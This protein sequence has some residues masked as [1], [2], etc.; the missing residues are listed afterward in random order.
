MI[1]IL[2]Y[3]PGWPRAF[4][5]EAS[6]LHAALPLLCAL[7]HIGSTAVPGLAAKPVIDMMGAVDSLDDLPHFFPVLGQ[8]GYS[9]VE[10]GMRDRSFL[11]RPGFNL[12][13]VTFASWPRR[14]ERLLRDA[15]IADPHAAARYGA[16]KQRLA[17]A[18]GDDMAAYTRAKT[19]FVQ[20]IMDQVHDRMGW[21]RED[22]WED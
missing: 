16:L 20:E 15:L 1:R 11:Q 4:F 9:L 7:E 21:P 10:T 6:A 8:R 18:H 5:V 17:A 14:K 22:V 3:D 12:H 13:L 2:P 19:A